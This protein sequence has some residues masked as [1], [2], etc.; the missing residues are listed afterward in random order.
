M[1]I[2]LPL[3][4]QVALHRFVRVEV[5]EM[6][7]VILTN[8]E[9][10]DDPL[11]DVGLPDTAS[12]GDVG[13][14]LK[15]DRGLDAPPILSC[16]RPQ[17][18]LSRW[19][20]VTVV[21]EFGEVVLPE[22]TPL[23]RLLGRPSKGV[24]R[25]FW[26]SASQH[27]ETVFRLRT[28]RLRGLDC[29]LDRLKQAR[30]VIAGLGLLGCEVATLLT[31]CGVGNLVLID[32]GTVD[33]TNI[34]R[35]RLYERRD[36]Y[37]EIEEVYFEVG[38]PFQFA[39][40]MEIAPEFELPEYKGLPAC[41]ETGSVTPEDIDRAL[42]LLGE[43]QTQFQTVARELKEGDV[44]VVNYT[45]SCDGK[46]VTETA[47][48]ARGLAEK[49]AFWINV[50]Q[51]SFIPGFGTQLTGMK[52]GDK[53][54]I[55]V[56]FPADFVTPQLAGKKGVYEVELV[57]AREKVAPELNEA[58]AKSYG[59]ESMEKL[60]EGVRADLQNEWNLK[61]SRSI[62]NQ[63]VQNLLGRI[64]CDLPESLLEQ[65]TREIVYSIVN[66]NQQRGVSKEALDAQ[67]DQIYARACQH[68]KERVKLA[69][70]L[71]RIAEVEGIRVA[72]E[73]VQARISAWAGRS[74][75][76]PAKLARD[77]ERC[78]GLRDVAR[79]ILHEEVL[80]LLEYYAKI[81]DVSPSS[82]RE[83]RKTLVPDPSRLHDE[84]R[85]HWPAN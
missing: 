22:D 66:E 8:G 61:Q 15:K 5:Q 26:K 50:D 72:P 67:R 20:A 68:A 21:D 30:I 71:E 74:N 47:P 36:V 58:F 59:A 78:D 3:K 12:I 10:A 85:S 35:Q 65:E 37:P 83:W 4:K 6:T 84:L 40:R 79:L 19:K 51:T 52:A 17:D 75:L 60:R 29:D 43:R 73:A 1:E 77:L 28:H 81:E 39:A 54:T 69:F 49:K 25:L 63:V 80:R 11:L 45:G 33:F 34:F 32:H 2:V 16:V 44:A 18:E 56:D 38:R 23:G 9:V 24:L 82:P 41:R 27:P 55:T 48:T 42:H 76:L 46:P 31:A 57:E 62:R 7:T 53:R 70:I 13:H 14:L 64:Q